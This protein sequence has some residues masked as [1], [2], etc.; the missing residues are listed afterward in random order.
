MIRTAT[1]GDFS[2]LMKLVKEFKEESPYKDK[3]V[4]Q[5]KYE[6]RVEFF[7]NPRPEEHIVFVLE[8]QGE[9]VGLIAGVV[10]IGEHIFSEDKTAVELVWYVTPDHRSSSGSLRLI[11]AYEKWAKLVGCTQSTMSNLVN[12]S[13]DRL[14]KIYNKLGYTLTEQTFTK[15]L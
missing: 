9:V 6:E 3:F 4:S 14:T 13:M 7:L 8:I 2:S 10:T 1:P 12:P 11:K 5:E 15:E